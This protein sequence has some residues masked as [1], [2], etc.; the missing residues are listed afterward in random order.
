MFSVSP[1]QVSVKWS[2]RSV[3]SRS[4]LLTLSPSH[5]TW[6][7]LWMAFTLNFARHYVHTPPAPRG[8]PSPAGETWS[9]TRLFWASQTSWARGTAPEMG[10]HRP[11]T[12]RSSQSSAI[13]T[14]AHSI[15]I[16]TR[17]HIHTHTPTATATLDLGT[18]SAGCLETHTWGHLRTVS[19]LVKWRGRGLSL[20]M[21]IC[22]CRSLMFLWCL[23]PVQQQLIR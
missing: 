5:P 20:I 18:C 13:T 11:H 14:V 23:V 7:W 21:T 1:L 9:S 3:A 12:L 4:A 22:Q 15:S 10:P 8:R 17:I 6:C 16:R 2:P 19:R